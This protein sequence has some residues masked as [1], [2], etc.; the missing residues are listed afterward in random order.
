MSLSHVYHLFR[1]LRIANDYL[2]YLKSTQ[3]N[4]VFINPKAQHIILQEQKYCDVPED[5]MSCIRS[6]DEIFHL[7]FISLR[8]YNHYLCSCLSQSLSPQQIQANGLLSLLLLFSFF[9]ATIERYVA[10]NNSLLKSDILF[11]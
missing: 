4:Y 7:L 3:W 8:A 5:Q 1:I 9:L 10:L 2:P 11:G 6:K